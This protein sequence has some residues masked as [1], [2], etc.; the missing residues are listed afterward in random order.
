MVSGF[1]EFYG[2][3]V[4]ERRC[5]CTRDDD[6]LELS[7]ENYKLILPRPVRTYNAAVVYYLKYRLAHPD[8]NGFIVSPS[9]LVSLSFE[10]HNHLCFNLWLPSLTVCQDA[11]AAALFAACKIEDTLKKSKEIL[12]AAYNLKLPPAEQLTPDD[13]V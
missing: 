6:Q 11:A 1:R 5:T 7:I 2:S 8:N 10:I 13:A 9:A 4:L 3:T 12:C